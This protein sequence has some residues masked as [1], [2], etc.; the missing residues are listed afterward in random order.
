[1]ADYDSTDCPKCRGP[2]SSFDRVCPFCHTRV[3]RYAALDSPGWVIL[4]IV[5]GGL[6]SLVMV[7]NTMGTGYL[8]SVGEW[9]KR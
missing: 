4:T 8:G 2:L 3:P 1:M 5:L 9:L 7:D 6:L